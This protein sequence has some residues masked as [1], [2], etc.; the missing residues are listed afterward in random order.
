MTEWLKAGCHM[1]LRS[2]WKTHL[3][4][5]RANNNDRLLVEHA[6]GLYAVLD[7]MG[8][9]CGGDVAAQLARD[10]MVDYVRW[11]AG[12]AGGSPRELLESSIDE[13]AMKV[14]AERRTRKEVQNMGTTVVACLHRAPSRIV[15]GHVGDSRAYLLHNSDLRLLTQDHTIAQQLLQLGTLRTK[16]EAERSPLR[17][18][19]TRNLGRTYGERPDI[20][21]LDLEL[22]DRLLLCSDGLYNGASE[23]AI[24]DVL[25]LQG[26]PEDVA[27]ELI[28]LALSGPAQD[29]ITALVLELEA[30]GISGQTFGRWRSN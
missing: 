1:K 3:G 5:S 8:G 27:N 26:E 23:D 15:I 12:V 9:H 19:L 22:G 25:S 30:S 6:L 10:T 16:E 18:H 14:F 28:D 13:A 2:G 4:N 29:D 24:Q 7:G 11:R 20:V 21:E 17:H